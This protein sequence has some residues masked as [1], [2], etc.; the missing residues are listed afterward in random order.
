[1]SL[2][3]GRAELSRRWGEPLG[4]SLCR[5]RARSIHRLIKEKVVIG[6]KARRNYTQR[7]GGK[8]SATGRMQQ[9]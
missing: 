1:M 7:E 2:L 8:A 6:R 4:S 3:Q 5:K 9:I